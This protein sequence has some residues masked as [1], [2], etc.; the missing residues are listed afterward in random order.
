MISKLIQGPR[1]LV[2]KINEIVHAVNA[3]SNLRGDGLVNVQK[4]DAGYTLRLAVDQVNARIPK[5]QGGS[6][7]NTIRRAIVS[8]TPGATD[9]VQCT[10]DNSQ[11]SAID[12]K[13]YISNG[14]ALDSAFPNLVENDSIL[15]TQIDGSWTCTTIFNG[16]DACSS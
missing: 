15:V 8:T 9:I 14:N 2:N 11:G 6:G 1:N 7:G 10:L 12:V 5:S 3:L 4:S 16:F 13:C